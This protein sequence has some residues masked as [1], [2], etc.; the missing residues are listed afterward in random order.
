MCVCGGDGVCEMNVCVYF[1]V[2]E[3]V[4]LCVSMVCGCWMSV[5]CE[6]RRRA[7]VGRV[8][9]TFVLRWFGV[10]FLDYCDVCVI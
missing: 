8:A 4:V 3:M 1:E 5:G 7:A 2:S 6:V 9:M 10:Y